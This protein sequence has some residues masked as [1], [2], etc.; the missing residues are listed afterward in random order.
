MQ[1]GK[2]SRQM[3]S[4]RISALWVLA[5][6]QAKVQK[7][8]GKAN[9]RPFPYAK[10]CHRW[11]RHGSSVV[12]LARVQEAEAKTSKRSQN[13]QGQLMHYHDA[14]D[15]APL[16]FRFA[17]HAQIQALRKVALLLAWKCSAMKPL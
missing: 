2:G 5:E 8:P 6:A 17:T 4:R 13:R 1:R 3:R 10:R 16:V 15:A 9:A 12:G 7:N 11:M 14:H